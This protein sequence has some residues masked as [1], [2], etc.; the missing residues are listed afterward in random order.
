VGNIFS[1][2]EQLLSSVNVRVKE[3]DLDNKIVIQVGNAT[4]E[5][6]AGS[7]EVEKEFLKLVG[8]SGR[9]DIVIKQTGCTGRCAA[10]PIVSVY[11]PQ[12]SPLKY[13]MVTPE[14]VNKIFIETVLN[15]RLVPDYLLDK[16]TNNIYKNLVTF[17]SSN[18]R[19]GVDDFDRVEYFKNKLAE[20]GPLCG[21]VKVSYGSGFGFRDEIGE[22]RN[23][24]IVYPEH[25]FYKAD[26]KEELDTI[27]A[28]HIIEGNIV[29]ELEITK[30]FL[31]ERFFETYGD[32]SFF[33]K[34]TRLTLRNSGIIDPESIE[35]YIHYDGFKALARVLDSMSPDDV[36]AEIKKSGLRG[37]GG[38]GFSTG[39]KWELTRKVPGERRYIICNADEGDP[40]AFM[41]RSTL[42][43]DP[44]SV[45]EGIIIGAYSIGA[46][47]AYIYIRA[48][49]PLAIERIEKALAKTKEYGFLGNTILGSPFSLDIE[50]RLGAG[51]F[52]CGE[53]TALIHSI[54]GKRGQPKI[55]PPYPSVK[56]LWNSPTCVNNVETFANVPV[57]ILYGADWFSGIGTRTSTGTKVFALA[58]DVRNTGLVEVPM[59]TTLREIIFDIGGGIPNNK[60]I[61]AIQTG[62]PSGGCIPASKIDTIVDYG[63]LISAGS[64]MGSGGMIVLSEDAC[65]VDVARFFL[66]FTKSESCGKCTPCREGTV[67]MLEILD[68][69]IAGKGTEEDLV[70]LVRLGEMIRKASLCGLG[71]A[72][73]NPV[74]SNLQNFKDEFL[75]HV[76]DKR[77]PSKKCTKLLRYVIDETKCIGC[78]LCARNCPVYCISG[79]AKQV[80]IIDQERC[81]KCGQC[82]TVCKFDAIRKE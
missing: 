79:K 5:N 13:E 45:L 82:H 62:G 53:E 31:A 10:E 66:D 64:F 33:N 47:R 48:E 11:L 24:V 15:Q 29:K 67:R 74:L 16:K 44:Y 75:A 26:T 32:V 65:M 81:I 20:C 70:R 21:T 59:G 42:E 58:G 40:G 73:P 46:S 71:Q 14:K 51:A 17:F 8:A 52:V 27:I 23:Y 1:Q 38:G 80:H 34:Q 78:T 56:G 43:G 18:V 54:E 9:K 39:L 77:C 22:N 25:V 55:K 63:S 61:K 6:A 2:Y 69:I 72:A 49:Y 68:R 7:R 12:K 41:D 3:S 37:R 76:R 4:C 50:V 19:K 60:Q 28:T 36:I 35:D 30:S 57:V